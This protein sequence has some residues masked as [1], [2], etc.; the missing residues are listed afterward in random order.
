MY[1]GTDMMIKLCHKESG[2]LVQHFTK[3][4]GDLV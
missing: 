2:D 1:Y 4:P 3:S